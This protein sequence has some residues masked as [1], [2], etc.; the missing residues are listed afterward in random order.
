MR[1]RDLAVFAVLLWVAMS[2]KRGGGA[3]SMQFAQGVERWRQPLI[4][5]GSDAVAPIGFLLAW[6][7]VESGGNNGAVGTPTAEG[8]PLDAD[9]FP[10]EVGIWQLDPGNRKIAGFTAAELRPNCPVQSGTRA[11]VEA[12][13]RPLTAPEAL[14][15]M[16]AGFNYIRWCRHEVDAALDAVHANADPASEWGFGGG[17]TPSYLRLVKSIHGS[18]EVVTVGIPAVTKK[19]GRAPRSWNELASTLRADPTLVPDL[20]KRRR[21]G[22]LLLDAVLRNAEQTVL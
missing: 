21:S 20:N 22:E 5:A 17:M 4:E 14:V 13:S 7:R 10:W 19:L 2:K 1:P 6:L 12:I 15:Q 9:G 8:G 3:S 16:Q 18:P 11:E